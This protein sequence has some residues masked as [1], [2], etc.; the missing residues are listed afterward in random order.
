MALKFGNGIE[1]ANVQQGILVRQFKDAYVARGWQL[2]EATVTLVRTALESGLD[3]MIR[4][5]PN[6]PQPH[7]R[8]P[9]G[10]G[11]VYLAFSA[12]DQHRWSVAIDTFN[13]NIGDYG[14]AVFNGKYRQQFDEHSIAFDFEK[15]NKESG[16]LVVPREAILETIQVV[17]GFDHRVLRAGRNSDVLKGFGTEYDIQAALLSGWHDT[18]LGDYPDVEEEFRLDSG[19]NS[20]RIDFLAQ[21]VNCTEVLAVEVKRAE[22]SAA[23]INQLTS[24]LDAL[25]SLSPFDQRRVVGALVAERIP[26]SVRKAAKEQ[27]IMAFQIEFPLV[28]Q[29]V[30]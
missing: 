15:R 5:R 6:H 17:G 24:Y 22:A 2:T 1:L 25:R 18:T 21:N 13:P 26:Q 14:H 8:W 20:K 28:L 19:P 3:W 16:H 10:K 29:R 30:A 12:S 4:N 27:R 23:A 7:A 11:R 9:N